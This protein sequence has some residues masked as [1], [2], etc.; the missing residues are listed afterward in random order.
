MKINKTAIVLQ[1]NGGNV[2]IGLKEPSEK[3]EV[4][5]T[6]LVTNQLIST[7][8]FVET[9]DNNNTHLVLKEGSDG[10]GIGINDEN[11]PI[12]SFLFLGPTGCGKT[13]T[14]RQLAKTLSVELLRFDMS[15]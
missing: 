9:E 4:N 2:G 7:K 1:E 14:A 13:E 10:V 6:M 15:A 3:L 11:R 8:P 5:G 12:G